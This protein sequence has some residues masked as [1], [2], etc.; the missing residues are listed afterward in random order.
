[1]LLLVGVEV[2]EQVQLS[3]ALAVVREDLE[4]GLVLQ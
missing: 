3:V 1:L 4:L 2:V